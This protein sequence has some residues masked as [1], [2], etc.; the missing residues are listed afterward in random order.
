MSAPA[1]RQIRG[2]EDAELRSQREF[3]RDP[4]PIWRQMLSLLNS[5]EAG[6]FAVVS[7]GV[8]PFLLPALTNVFLLVGLLTFAARMFSVRY[9]R[10]PF[11]LP[12]SSEKTDYSDP[13]P[14]RRGFDKAGGVFYVGNE[15]RNVYELWLRL[16]DIL[17][18]VLV[19]GTTGSGKTETL[20][21][22]AFNFL[23]QGSGFVYVDPKGAP[24]L[25]FQIYILCRMLGRDMDFRLLSYSVQGKPPERRTPKR[26]ANTTNPFAFG[27]AE[28][29]TQI[30]VALLPPT[31]GG[32][33]VFQQNAQ[34]MITALMY[35]LVELRDRGELDLSIGTIR[36]YMARHK[37]VE[38]AERNDLSGPTTNALRSFLRSVG[39]DEHKPFAQQGKAFPEQYQYAHAYFGLA[40]ASLTD[41]YGHIYLTDGGEVDMYD[42]I[43]NRRVLVVILPALEMAPEQLKNT[44]QITLSSV[45]KACA[46]GLGDKLQGTVQD[47]LEALPTGAR[48]AFG[49]ITDE[50]A[51]IP[52]PG[53]AEVL[54]QGRGLGISAIVASQDY[55]GITKA[56]QIGAKQIVAN[57]KVKF[58]MKQEDAEDT[59]N[60]AKN[61]AAEA[62]AVQ[63]QG[64]DINKE[65]MSMSYRD[66]M[67][68]SVTKME[69]INLLDLQEQIEGEF[70]A[71]FNG[72]IV[73]G[74]SFYANPPLKKHYQ[75][76]INEMM[77]VG[78]P[79]ARQLEM[80]VGNLREAVDR[81]KNAIDAGDGIVPGGTQAPAFAS[82]IKAFSPKG[83]GR[84]EQAILALLNWRESAEDDVDEIMDVKSAAYGV[85]DHDD[86]QM[87]A[88]PVSV[89]APNVA[90][91]TESS[92]ADEDL[93]LPSG[94]DA[95]VVANARDTG[96]SAEATE[97]VSK[98]LPFD[99]DDEP[100]PSD[101]AQ[102]ASWVQS[103][104]QATAWVR[105]E[106]LGDD[107]EAEAEI[108]QAEELLGASHDKARET[109][110][111]IVSDIRTAMI[112]PETPTPAKTEERKVELNDAIEHLLA[113]AK[114]DD[115]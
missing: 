98:A 26:L 102:A 91:A 68:A 39:W 73:R 52:T 42:V 41:T 17:T 90:S 62:H 59:W 61:T 44:G 33:S 11:R 65:G 6:V 77:F 1:T 113:R 75:L 100:A 21:S 9:S 54:T 108:A 27:F 70:H 107:E 19:F 104:Q 74:F 110:R 85:V 95:S 23:T 101:M 79:N 87:P 40:L 99:P 14:G 55:A 24:K 88:Q 80:V 51:A 115:V 35:G 2:L 18:H 72:T 67:S 32:N 16:K 53:Y 93:F 82:V 58:F 46:V 38:L 4:R 5:R 78:K 49:A 109:A 3:I 60:L 48:N 66:M 30:L 94:T 57:T 25:A 111:R 105:E 7:C 10:L 76:R 89:T 83:V 92:D 56:D 45:R 71:F 69:R 8:A 96:K 84:K 81:F 47:V 20:V 63:T 50:Y 112:Y 12:A 103:M 64:Y 22:F 34:T 86:L 106:V 15:W 43:K 29:L 37:Y 97:D 13:K 31:E 28:S 36:E 114:Q